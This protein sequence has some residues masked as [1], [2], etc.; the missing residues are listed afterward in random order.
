MSLAVMSMEKTPSRRF[1]SDLIVIEKLSQA[2]ADFIAGLGKES[3]DSDISNQLRK[4]LLAEQH[5]L[6]CAELIQDISFAQAETRDIIDSEAQERIAAYRADVVLFLQSADLEKQDYNYAYSHE[7]FKHIQSLH[8]ET[9]EWLLYQATT[10]RLPVNDI[11]E[12]AE[13]NTRIRRLCKKMLKAL[14]DIR[15]VMDSES[16][17]LT[18]K[19]NQN[20][21]A[22]NPPT[23]DV[24][25]S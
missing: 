3:I 13:Q 6:E 23:S 7:Q 25:E 17:V 5:I 11:I 18:D 12:V 16:I 22:V 9:R 4:L 20:N 10:N 19:S 14:D 1:N 2:V 8:D 24:L 15:E 21:Q